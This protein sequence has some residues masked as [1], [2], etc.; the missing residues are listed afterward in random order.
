MSTWITGLASVAAAAL[1]L[2]FFAYK[3]N[4]W[5]LWVV[6]GVTLAGM[7]ADLVDTARKRSQ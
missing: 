7:I 4:A 3:V 5:P 6:I 1:F 2:G